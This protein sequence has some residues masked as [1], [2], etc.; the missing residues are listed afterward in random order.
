MKRA[1]VVCALLLLLGFGTQAYGYV[2]VYRLYGTVQTVDTVSE[3]GDSKYLNGYMVLNIDDE[4][5]ACEESSV[6]LYARE[7]WTDRV[8]TI[9]NDFIELKTYGDYATVMGNTGTG[10]S[11]ILTGRTSRR[12]MGIPRMA[13]AARTLSGGIAFEWGQLFD[14]DELLVG[15]GA[16][17]GRLD[18]WSTWVS[19]SSD[20]GFY[21]SVNSILDDLESRRYKFVGTE[22]PPADEPPADEPPDE[23]PP[24]EE[25]P[26]DGP[27]PT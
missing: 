18:N 13:S 21:E 16:L 22:E 27:M 7:R 12:N 23:E 4:T 11:I 5:G 19:N 10:N 24:E 9:F 1:A 25:P 14:P 26:D 15:A 17:Q 2:L 8:Y 6:I 20:E 3:D